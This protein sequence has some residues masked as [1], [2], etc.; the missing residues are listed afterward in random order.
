MPGEDIRTVPRSLAVAMKYRQVR[1]FAVAVSFIAVTFVIY[2]ASFSSSYPCHDRSGEGCDVGRVDANKPLGTV[3]RTSNEVQTLIREGQIVKRSTSDNNG[4]LDD[5]DGD[6]DDSKESKNRRKV[7]GIDAYIREVEERHRKE[8]N[9]SRLKKKR[10]KEKIAPT[11]KKQITLSKEIRNFPVHSMYIQIKEADSPKI[12]DYPCSA[13]V[14]PNCCAFT[15]TDTNEAKRI[16]EA[17]GKFCKGFVMSTISSNVDSFEYIMYLKK[18]LNGTMA[19][20]LTDFFIKVDF[21]DEL[22]WNEK[23]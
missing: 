17:F 19:N 2:L 16:C 11:K 3:H 23:R 9:L 13:T 1:R 21:L 5:G 12:G 8:R 15:I 20:Y 4:G 7:D 18:D 22:R 6:N 10:A 14:V